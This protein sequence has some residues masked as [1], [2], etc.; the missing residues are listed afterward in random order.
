[1]R[2][3]YL[4]HRDYKSWLVLIECA[5]V[6]EGA[7]DVNRASAMYHALGG[8]KWIL[9]ALFRTVW[10]TRVSA[11]PLQK[12]FA[13]VNK[14]QPRTELAISK[15]YWPLTCTKRG[16]RPI[17]GRATNG[18]VC[19]FNKIQNLYKMTSDLWKNIGKFATLSTLVRLDREHKDA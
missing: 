15:N 7:M 9:N 13:V 11:L 1:M 4:Q 14:S 18:F 10:L 5:A 2:D 12:A 8:L 16:K 6:C 19:I 3:R 17:I